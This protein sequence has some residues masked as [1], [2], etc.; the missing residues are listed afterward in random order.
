M[1]KLELLGAK[2]LTKEEMNDVKGGN[3]YYCVCGNNSA[4][5]YGTYASDA[6]AQQRANYWCGGSE[7]GSCV[8]Y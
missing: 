5:W 3:S 4:M 7:T 8:P 2:M 6:R 1:K